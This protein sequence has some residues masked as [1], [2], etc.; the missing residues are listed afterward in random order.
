MEQF[1][2][3]WRKFKISR[4]NAGISLVFFISLIF[5]TLVFFSKTS[6]RANI[7]RFATVKAKRDEAPTDG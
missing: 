3:I 4:R 5:S 6:I 7:R 2:T 1:A